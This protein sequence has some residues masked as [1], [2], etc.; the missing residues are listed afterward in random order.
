LIKIAIIGQ[1]YVGLSLAVSAANAGYDVIGYDVNADLVEK[2]IAGKSHVEGIELIG[3]KNY[4]PTSDVSLIDGSEVVVIAVPTPLNQ[5]RKPDLTYLLA[6]CETIGKN[7]KN[8]AL[9][10]NESTSFPAPCG[11]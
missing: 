11:S 3:I 9:I 4:Q 1:G 8:R 6:V 5:E 2:L 10:I 7:L